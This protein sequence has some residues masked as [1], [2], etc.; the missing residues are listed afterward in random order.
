[1][2]EIDI[3]IRLRP[4]DQAWR[5]F[6]ATAG[7]GEIGMMRTV[8]DRIKASVVKFQK[9]PEIVVYQLDFLFARLAARDHGLIGHDDG[10]VPRA[11][12]AVN[13]LSRAFDQPDVARRKHGIDFNVEGAVAVQE[14]RPLAPGRVTHGQPV[15]PRPTSALSNA[16]AASPV[17]RRESDRGRTPPPE[18]RT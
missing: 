13:S 5:G 1:M 12:D 4:Q 9:S 14:N 11:I 3:E 2:S 16:P 15:R 6:S 10:A 17:R 7:A 8:V 18:V